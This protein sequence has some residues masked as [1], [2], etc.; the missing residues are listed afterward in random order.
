MRKFTLGV[1]ALA[2]GLFAQG[3]APTSADAMPLAKSDIAAKQDGVTQVRRDGHRMGGANFSRRSFSGNRFIGSNHIGRRHIGIN[4]IGRHRFHRRH[5]R[6]F[7][8]PYFYN[9]YNDYGGCYW[10]K[11]KALYTGSRYWWNRYWECRNG[12]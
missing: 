2:A 3:F 7:I 11:R 9:S 12:Y 8:G 1:L 5:H 4:H 6:F 10:L